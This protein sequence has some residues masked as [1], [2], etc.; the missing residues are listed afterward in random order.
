GRLSRRPNSG[1]P[2]GFLGEAAVDMTTPSTER[3]WV[4]RLLAAVF[5]GLCSFLIVI[6]NKQ[7]LTSY[8]FPSSLFLGVGQMLVTLVLLHVGR[9]CGLVSFP[10]FDRNLPKKIFPLPLIYLGNHITGLISTKRLSLP[11][12]TVLRKFSILFTMVGEMFILGKT[13]SLPIQLTVA[14]MMGGAIF[15]ASSDLA[16]DPVGYTFILAN[17]LF[18]A[19]NGVYT[20]QKLDSQELGKYG[21]LYYN[22]VFMIVPAALACAYTGDLQLKALDFEGWSNPWFVVHFTFACFMGFI[23]LFSIILCTQY[24]SALT[25]TIVGCLKYLFFTFPAMLVGGDYIFS[26]PNFV[27]LNI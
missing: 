22:A 5:Y 1:F 18:T 27:G 4:S 26:W 24:N 25:T 7:V 12:F 15:A 17:D 11:M 20:K 2:R 16:F 6:V 8:G 3:H 13:T 23:L 10:Y 19:A 9:V 14:M 21:L